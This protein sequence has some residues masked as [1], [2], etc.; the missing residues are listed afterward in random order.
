MEAL[1]ME[2]LLK[3]VPLAGVLGKV[4][5]LMAAL[6]EVALLYRAQPIC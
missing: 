2:A 1:L 6:Q 4:V 3:E 5:R